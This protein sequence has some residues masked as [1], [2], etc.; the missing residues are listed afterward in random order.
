MKPI[1][2][3][4]TIFIAFS[5]G[6]TAQTPEPECPPPPYDGPTV[7]IVDYHDCHWYYEC[8]EGD[9]KHFE[10]PPDQYFDMFE[11]FCGDLSNVTCS[12]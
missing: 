11:F 7:F 2:A 3:A 5:S 9:K 4:I 12:E 10:C 8:V 1:F 6:A